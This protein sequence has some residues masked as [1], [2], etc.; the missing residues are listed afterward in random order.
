MKLTVYWCCCREVTLCLP[1]SLFSWVSL[2]YG[3]P[4]CMWT[5]YT[6][7]LVAL[8]VF[9]TLAAEFFYRFFHELPFRD[10]NGYDDASTL[11]NQ[12]GWNNRLQLLAAA[13]AFS[14]VALYIRYVGLQIPCS[15]LPEHLIG[16]STVSLS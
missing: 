8:T 7:D 2:H 4:V 10:S 16:Q 6:S 9:M 15:Q 1:E 12:H 3:P 14:T 11:N 5:N 13:M